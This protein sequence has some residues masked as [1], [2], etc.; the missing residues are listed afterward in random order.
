MISI[1]AQRLDPLLAIPGV[2]VLVAVRM[3]YLLRIVLVLP[4]N[5]APAAFFCAFV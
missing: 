4:Q 5:S 3:E 2:N 1:A